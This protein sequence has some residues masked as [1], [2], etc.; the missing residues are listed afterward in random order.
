MIFSALTF[1]DLVSV[2]G[3]ALYFFDLSGAKTLLS[4]LELS[5]CFEISSFFKT[6]DSGTSFLDLLA[7][8]VA[9]SCFGSS[10]VFSG[11]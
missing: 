2:I 5:L 3:S 4:C 9:R 1:W 7:D 11:V 6:S 8:F 10:C